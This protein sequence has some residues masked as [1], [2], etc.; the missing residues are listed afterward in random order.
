[1]SYSV[2]TIDLSLRSPENGRHLTANIYY[3][4][5]VT[6]ATGATRP[7]SIG[8]LVMAICLERAAKLESDIIS[9]MNTMNNT[10]ATLEALSEIETKIVDWAGTRTS[11]STYDLSSHTISSGQYKGKTYKDFL[12]MSDVGLSLPGNQVVI[13]GTPSSSQLSY[14]EFISRLEAKMD[15]KNSF[16]QQKMIEL[17]SLT[18]KRDQSYDMI[19][20]ILKSFNTVLIGNVN[21]M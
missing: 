17:Q 8:Q 15:E 4:D 21:N 3:V 9:L 18:A 5:G 11:A 19:S 10:T 1:M 20:N 13:W 14:D 6:D 16:S 7:L 12:T 2:D